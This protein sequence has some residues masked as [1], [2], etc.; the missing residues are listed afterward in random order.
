M[1]KAQNNKTRE[2]RDY[3]INNFGIKGRQWGDKLRKRKLDQ[4]S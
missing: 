3:I 4:A 2:Y 1:V